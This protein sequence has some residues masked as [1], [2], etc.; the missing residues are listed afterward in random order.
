MKSS[1]RPGGRWSAEE[2]VKAAASDTLDAQYSVVVTRSSWAPE[3]HPEGIVAWE[4]LQ[5]EDRQLRGTERQIK[6]YRA[7]IQGVYGDRKLHRDTSKSQVVQFSVRKKNTLSLAR[8]KVRRAKFIPEKVVFSW[9]R[10]PGFHPCFLLVQT[11]PKLSALTMSHH[12]GPLR[13][14]VLAGENRGFDP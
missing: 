3:K 4:S 1:P 9:S 2:Q 13:P 8:L 11:P 7:S 12:A 10:P 14:L 5:I 6:F